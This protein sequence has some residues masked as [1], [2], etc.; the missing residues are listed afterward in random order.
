MIAT[1]TAMIPLLAQTSTS[2]PFEAVTNTGDGWSTPISI[3]ALIVA[4][5]VGTLTVIQ[6]RAIR[7]IETREHDWQATDRKSAHI[8]VTRWRENLTT[9][10]TSGDTRHYVKDWIRLKNTGLAPGHSVTWQIE[11]AAS[12]EI[13][14]ETAPQVL[15]V[16]H[17]GEHFDIWLDRSHP[18]PIAAG[19][20]VSWTDDLGNHTTQRLINLLM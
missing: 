16:L 9:G 10:T 11:H 5:A 13:V 18:N 2:V 19:F 3:V 6:G 15:N 14:H 7:Q 4:V 8:Q 17:P 1:L 20:T 12:H